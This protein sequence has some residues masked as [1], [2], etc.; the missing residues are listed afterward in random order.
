MNNPLLTI[1]SEMNQR[2]TRGFRCG[3]QAAVLKSNRGVSRLKIGRWA[4]CAFE[5][6][7]SQRETL[8]LEAVDGTP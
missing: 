1:A 7:V 2:F 3:R 8:F 6:R 4:D 5:V